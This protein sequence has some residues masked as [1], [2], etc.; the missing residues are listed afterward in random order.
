MEGDDTMEKDLKELEFSLRKIGSHQKAEEVNSLFQDYL[1][2]T[3]MTKNASLVKIAEMPKTEP[4]PDQADE[5]IT[6]YIEL[7]NQRGGNYEF[8][9]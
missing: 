4:W 2:H 1:R 6:Y 3:K 5:N 9:S 7:N 8:K